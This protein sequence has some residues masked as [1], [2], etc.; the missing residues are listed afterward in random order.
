MSHD[1][2]FGETKLPRQ[3]MAQ[4]CTKL[5]ECAGRRR[6]VTLAPATGGRPP[7]SGR[8]GGR[9]CGSGSGRLSIQAMQTISLGI[10]PLRTS[11]LA[12][13]CW[14]LAGSWNPG[15]VTTASEAAGRRAVITAFEA[16][17]TLF[18]NADIYCQG[19]AE[20]ILGEALKE[21]PGMRE[22]VVV[23]TKVGIRR[24]GVPDPDAP[25]RWDFSADYVV[26]ATEASLA[27]LAVETIDLLMLHRPDWLA[28]PAEVAAAFAKLQAAGKVR[29]FGLSNC[30][31]TLFAALQRACPMPLVVHQVEISLARLAAFEDGTLDQCLSERVTPMAWSPLAAGL[32]GDGAS[33]LLSW[34]QNYRTEAIVAALQQVAVA[35]GV[36][37]TAV[38]LAWLLKHPAQIQPI[39]GSGKPERIRELAQAAELE[40][41]REEWY[42]LLLAAR[43]EPLP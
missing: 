16:G 20:R 34:Q 9:A 11:R 6:G 35:R 33:R 25:A 12:F 28:D 22:R 30:R 8:R 1:G 42:R 14:R 5:V 13:G 43:G 29:Y 7:H 2:M 32:L 41:T 10:S 40:L 26:A 15:E 24:A 4:G 18:D 36:S 19:I 39:V 31:P 21:V 37:R 23:A 27:R 38:A 17:Y 3:I